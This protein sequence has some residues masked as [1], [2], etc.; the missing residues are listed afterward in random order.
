MIVFYKIAMINN[1][2]IFNYR[3]PN[4]I[5]YSFKWYV[6]SSVDGREI[7]KYTLLFKKYGVQK[8][9][10]STAQSIVNRQNKIFLWY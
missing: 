10:N 2:I 8:F 5:K 9:Q 7:C 1:L 4:Y 6:V 3:M